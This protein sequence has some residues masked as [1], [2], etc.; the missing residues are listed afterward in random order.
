MNALIRTTVVALVVGL[1]TLSV[2]ALRMLYPPNEAQEDRRGEELQRLQRATLHRQEARR[3]AVQEWIA[4]HR[5]LAETMERF[6][7]LDHDWPD[8]SEARLREKLPESDVER[9]Y[10]LILSYMRAELQGRS[11]ELAAVLRRLENEYQ[12]L[13]AGR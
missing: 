3:Q 4:R 1:L 2:F 10:R 5:S 12:Q 6:Q 13:Q 7:E 9:H 8:Y 11:E